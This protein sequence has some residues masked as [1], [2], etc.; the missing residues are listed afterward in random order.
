LLEPVWSLFGAPQ[1]AAGFW[2]PDRAD[3][4]PGG[5][6]AKD[7]END[8]DPFAVP[9]R[10]RCRRIGG[11]V[12]IRKVEEPMRY[13]N[14]AK[15][16]KF[17]VL[18]RVA[19]LAY[20]GDLEEKSD[21]IPY[22]IIPGRVARFRCC[23]YREREILRE[24]VILARGKHLPTNPDGSGTVTVLPAACEGCPINR[25]TVTANCQRCMA[26][27]CVAACP[28]GAITV[29]G[30]GAYIDPA[31][32]KECGRCAAACPYN[33]ISD[34]MRPCLRS[35]PVDAITMDENK[36]ASIKYERCIGC[37]AC[38][39]DCPFG[40]I[41][42][43]SSIV[44]VIEQ[45]KGK[46]QVYAMFAPA[47]EGQFGTATVGMLKAAL[48]KLGF[49]DS[50]EVA[51]GADAVAQHEAHELKEAIQTGRK[52][53]TSCCPAFF[54]M[55][56]KHF[57]KLIPNISSTVSP[58]TATARYVKYLHPHALTVFIGP[59]IAKKQEI[60]HVKDS[61]DYVLTFEEL[62]AMFK[63]QNVDP[64]EMA[65]DVQ[66]GSVYGKG[67]AQ[68]GGVSGAVMEVLDEEGFEMP[69]TCRKCMGA[70]ECKKALI[71]MNAG[72]MP[73][74]IIEGMACPG[75]CLDGPAAVDTLQKVV[76]NRS[77]LLP[78]ADKRTI[79]ENVLEHGFD[80]IKMDD[81]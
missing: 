41:S 24:R 33:A 36:Q 57:P 14:D 80:K 20:A 75:G 15:Q 81:L 55:I 72:K 60:Q 52:M 25:F 69:V 8:Q 5:K 59:C 2:V 70:K 11:R 79:T 45:L 71:A 13:D 18:L 6:D 56:K 31:K 54:T 17:E 35:C 26:K 30:S 53:T 51:L 27:K 9:Y 50:F 12:T 38:T 40:A 22:D 7:L 62:A 23:V 10:A 68:S 48:K 77:K 46:K 21:S 63:A 43:T 39:M 47:I 29:T 3:A 4:Y 16:M 61:A 78:K 37:G 58:M 67:F 42:D 65:D 44:E 74:N 1:L 34:T 28:F 19:Q 66:D 49:D 73:E 32:C 76:K 64:M